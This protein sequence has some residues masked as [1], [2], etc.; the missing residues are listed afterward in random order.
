MGLDTYRTRTS[1]FLLIAVTMAGCAVTIAGC[2]GPGGEGGS[3]AVPRASLGEPL[4]Q[5]EDGLGSLRGARELADGRV[6]IADGFGEALIVWAP[7]AGADTLTNVGQGPQE[8]QLPD[9][10]FPL[11]DGGTLLVDLGNVRL[12]RIDADLAFGETWP[13]A[14]GGLGPDMTMMLPGATDREGRIYYEARIGGM[15][16]GTDS[17]AIMRFDPATDETEEIGRIKLAEQERTE[18]GD[19]NNQNVSIRPVP[20][21]AEDAW[22]AAWDGRVAIARADGYRLEWL[23]SDGA[24]TLGGPVP[25]EPVA[26]GGADREE[27]LAALGGGLRVEVT[28]DGGAPR[29]SMSRAPA[30]AG[31]ATAAD[32]I[33]PPVKPAFAPDGVLSDGEGRAWVRRHVPAGTPPLF[34]IFD[35]R[36]ERIAQVELPEDRRLVSI[37]EGGVYLS[38]SDE[39]DFAW[40]EK[41]AIPDIAG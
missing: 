32:F 25:Y 23:A 4:A 2:A 31:E 38:R 40:L 36:G 17:A 21:S 3:D 34:D 41:Y 12:T 30:G 37:G 5:F 29:M 26:I 27:W 10:L 9:G 7:G 11:P 13:I 18:S 35:A 33:W 19:A 39:F 1:P 28:A 24:A 14:R 20:Y 16:A 6:L 8:Y 15:M 22:G